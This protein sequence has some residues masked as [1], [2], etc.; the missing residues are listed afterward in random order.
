MKRLTGL[1]YIASITTAIA[2]M[3]S[4]FEAYAQQ[5]NEQ[6]Q[7]LNYRDADLRAFIEDVAMETR[8]T[9]IL[10]PSVKG[11]VNIVSASAIGDE[12]LFDTLLSVLKVNGY[13]LTPTSIGH[14]KVS[15]IVDS[16]KD[17]TQML[18]NQTGDEL[19]TRIFTVKYSDPLSLQAALKPY[20]HSNGYVF[21]RRDLPYVIVT[22]FAD[23]ILKVSQIIQS[24][25]VDRR[26]VKNLFGE[27]VQ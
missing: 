26:V 1:R 10:D 8:K 22:D 18:D 4:T 12:A 23:N 9:F 2:L 24:I 17:R 21:A 11:K 5:N 13:A 20:L 7:L 25:D 16:V 3:A 15:K 14:Y 19:V 6:G 27:T